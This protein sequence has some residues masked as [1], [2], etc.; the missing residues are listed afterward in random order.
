MA[1][2]SPL[3]TSTVRGVALPRTGL[4]PDAFDDHR[5]KL[6]QV[7]KLRV[8]DAIAERAGRDHHRVLQLQSADFNGEIHWITSGFEN[9]DQHRTTN[10]ERQHRADRRRTDNSEFDVRF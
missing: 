2:I 10:I 4:Q 9:N 3:V 7:E 8:F 5:A 1:L 6:V